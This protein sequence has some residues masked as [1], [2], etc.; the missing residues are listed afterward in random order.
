MTQLVELR[1]WGRHYRHTMPVPALVTG[2]VATLAIIRLC[3]VIQ[4]AGSTPAGKD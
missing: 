1:H 4:Q 3:D 2:P